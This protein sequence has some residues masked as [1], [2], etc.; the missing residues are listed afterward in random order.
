MANSTTDTLLWHW[1][2]IEERIYSKKQFEALEDETI[3]A[4][5][6]DIL[7]QNWI[8]LCENPIQGRHI[9]NNPATNLPTYIDDPEPSQDVLLKQEEQQLKAYL[10]ETDYQAIKCG[11]L[12]LSMEE[13]YPESYQ[14]RIAARARINEI[15]ALLA[16]VV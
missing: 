13:E 16:G 8:A 4:R 5:C 1:D 10:N 9:G 3:K 2:P 15:E 7:W 12:G 14:Q 11:E 6:T